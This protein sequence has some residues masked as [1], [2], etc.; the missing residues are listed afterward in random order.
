M[1]ISASKYYW[2][3]FRC[4]TL[5]FTHQANFGHVRIPADFAAP[6]HHIIQQP[7]GYDPLVH[8]VEADSVQILDTRTLQINNLTYD[9][10]G[11]GKD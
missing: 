11:P 10:Q 4:F 5:S 6:S 9:G 2:T 8:L 3:S 7:L 1:M